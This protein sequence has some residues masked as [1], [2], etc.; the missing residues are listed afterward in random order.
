[1]EPEDEDAASLVRAAL[2]RDGVRVLTGYKALR[3]LRVGEKKLMVLESENGEERLEFDQLL[4]AV[5]RAA[6][7][8]GYGLEELGIE[9]GRTIHTNEYMQTLQRNIYAAGDV[10]GPYQLTHVS[11]HQAWYAS[12]NAL[13]GQLGPAAGRRQRGSRRRA[14]RAPP[15][16]GRCA[17]SR[18]S[19]QQPG[20]HRRF[21][22]WPC[23]PAASQS[24]RGPR[25]PP[26]VS[27]PQSRD[28]LHL[29]CR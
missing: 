12:V 15:P 14:S 22:P 2:E 16:A 10:A 27:S 6:R 23:R 9:T 5:G 1:M 20:P 13:F 11:A 25:P 28:L 26:R 19:L 18:C 21:P 29:N 7:L 4:V 8:E 17:V 3:C 24:V